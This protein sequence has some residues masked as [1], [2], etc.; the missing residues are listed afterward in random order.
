MKLI[1]LGLMATLARQAGGGA[2]ASW[3]VYHVG[4]RFGAFWGSFAS[5][6]PEIVWAL[7][8][9]IVS[10][11]LFELSPWP[12][13]LPIAI[14][15]Y[16]AMETG[17]G[18]AYHMGFAE[19]TFPDRWQTLDYV[20]RPIMRGITW[21]AAYAGLILSLRPRSPIYCWLFMGLKGLLIGLPLGIYGLPL[22]ILWPLA[23]YISFRLT[24]SS[25]TAEWLSGGFAGL[26]MIF[27]FYMR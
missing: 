23:Y 7:V 1:F 14:I 26:T 18:N 13:A 16:L 5:R 22:A 20:V 4:T 12:S 27:A 15:A 3:L 8:F 6:L 19:T 2:G 24:R 10:V 21:V 25:E 17:H 9:T 11:N